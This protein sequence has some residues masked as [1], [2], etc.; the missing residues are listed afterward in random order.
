MSDEFDSESAFVALLDRLGVDEEQ[1]SKAWAFTTIMNRDY[2]VGAAAVDLEMPVHDLVDKRNAVLRMLTL[3]GHLMDQEQIEEHGHLVTTL[4]DEGVGEF[5]H[6]TLIRAV[7]DTWEGT[8][9]K[10]AA[11]KFGQRAVAVD[12]GRKYFTNMMLYMGAEAIKG[13]PYLTTAGIFDRV[14]NIEDFVE[15]RSLAEDYFE[16][17]DAVEDTDGDLFEIDDD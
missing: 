16:E 1:L 7:M 12:W 9:I 3:Y 4:T 11:A 5:S 10:E 13:S 15:L 14:S 17:D 8:S 2:N 6:L